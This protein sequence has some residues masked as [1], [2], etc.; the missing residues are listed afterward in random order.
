M[1]KILFYDTCSL[2]NAQKEVF[3]TKSKFYISS[4]TV[5]ELENIKTSGYKDEQIKYEARTLLHLLEQNEDKYNIVL[6][7]D[8]SFSEIISE[9]DLPD[10]PDSKII[11]T[12]FYLSKHLDGEIFFCTEDLACKAIAKSLGL[13]VISCGEEETKEVYTGYYEKIYSDEEL[14]NFYNEIFSQNKNSYNLLDNE[15]LILKDKNNKVIDKY[16]WI[17]N[18][19]EPVSYYKAE[20][21][22]F[23]KI[24]PKNG[25]I[26]QQLALDSLN[27][28]QISMLRGRAG[29]GKSYL[30]FGYMFSLLEHGKID[31][32]IIFC[33]TVA[34]KGSA[35]LGFYPGSRTEKLLDS[36]IGNLLESKLG[37]RIAVERL[38]SD[39]KLILLPLS[40]IRGYDTT[41][42][43]AAVYISEAQ[44]LDI[45]LM[46]LALQRIGEDG[47]C[48]ID[49]DFSHQVDMTQYSGNNNGM[50]RA[51][52]VFR[53]A[54]FYGEVELQ[55]IYRSKIAERA[56]LM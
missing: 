21:R 3:K 34:T 17:D 54:P 35:K 15:Y 9:F 41:N 4:I 11:A 30:A 27:S 19:Y 13:S 2:L 38:I 36:Q 39:G 29:T 52:E 50:R 7:K 33:N 12:A 32:I 55:T 53:G 31:K 37:D 28:N 43:N 51:S 18:H 16:K 24:S 25:D 22:I 46:R 23:G 49:G 8:K 45:E 56:E 42:M 5:N 20:S 1:N 40:D 10:T 26:Y 44:N 6:Y 48:I 47:I 14:A